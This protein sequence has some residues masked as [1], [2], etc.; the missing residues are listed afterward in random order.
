MKRELKKIIKHNR[1]ALTAS[2]KDFASIYKIMFGFRDK[3][4]S[5]YD[6]GFKIRKYT[7]GEVFDMIERAAGSLYARIGATHGFVGL[8]AENCLE[9]IIAFWAILKS[10][11]KPYLVNCRHPKALSNGIIE[12]LGIK[13]VLSMKR[14]ELNA[15]YIIIPSLLGDSEKV[16]EGIFE[17]EIALSTSA[18]TLKETVCYYG[19]SEIAEQIL[20]SDSIIKENKSIAA[21]CNGELK[22]L[23]FLPFY[24]IFGLFAVYFWFSFYARSFVFLH[25]YSP[26]TILKACRKHKVTHIF[27]VPMLWHTIEDKLKKELSQK[28]EKTKKRFERGL[29]ISTSLQNT[30]PVFG[31]HIARRLMR[32]VTDKVFG[33]SVRFCISGGSYI[34]QSALELINGIGY[35]LYNGYGM[36][37]VGISSVELRSKPKY[38]CENSIGKPFKSVEYRINDDSTLEI[39]GSSICSRI[40]VSGETRILDGWFN[41]GDIVEEKNGYYFIKGRKGDLVIGESGEN[42]N[43]DTIEQHF[44]L[45]GCKQLSVLGLKNGESETLAMVIQISEYSTA[46]RLKEIVDEIYAINDSLPSAIRIRRF[47]ITNDPIVSATAVKVSRPYLQ[48]EIASGAIR[49]K[50]VAEALSALPQ[51]S[52]DGINAQIAEKVKEAV[53]EVLGIAVGEIENDVHFINDL[54][55]SSLQYFAI[56]GILSKEFGITADSESEN[57]CYT[58]RECTKYIERYL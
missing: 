16:P 57:Y 46:E 1:E 39:K 22:Q 19:G 51:N 32:E 33:S 44:S 7:Y 58:V 31:G 25:D 50:T 45:A 24:H 30:F 3:L 14:G 26:E 12:T 11:N 17:N 8:E 37:E 18:T 47:Y 4:F 27:A 49:L 42:I 5:E 53:S 36:S 6:D 9:W 34:R 40:T 54:S 2:K 10:G 13:T 29:G 48:R 23:A 52:E 41:T 35:P 15:D 21:H 55:A 43:P 20:N 28:G 56:L 38:R